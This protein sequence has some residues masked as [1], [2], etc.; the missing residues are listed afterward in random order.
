MRTAIHMGPPKSLE[1]YVQESGRCGRDGE[2]NHA[3]I[4][5]NSKLLMHVDDDVK[6]YLLSEKNVEK[7]LSNSHCLV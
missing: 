2:Q 1:A 7:N 5:F 6:E 4:L 3:I